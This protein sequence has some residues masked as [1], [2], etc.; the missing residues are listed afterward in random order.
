MEKNDEEKCNEKLK[1]NWFRNFSIKSYPYFENDEIVKVGFSK[2][3]EFI[4]LLTNIDTLLISEYD[5]EE[6][7]CSLLSQEEIYNF[8]IFGED[9]CGAF[10]LEKSKVL[11]FRGFDLIKT[12]SIPGTEEKPPFL[13]GITSYSPKI[14]SR[15]SFLWLVG[16]EGLKQVNFDPIT[17]QANSGE[18]LTIWKNPYNISNFIIL[19]VEESEKYIFGLAFDQNPKNYILQ[20]YDLASK[21]ST[22]FH[23]EI[24]PVLNNKIFFD[25]MNLKSEHESKF[26]GCGMHGDP[27]G[28]SIGQI[29]CFKIQ[30]NIEEEKIELTQEKTRIFNEYSKFIVMRHLQDSEFFLGGINDILLV[31]YTGED[32][33]IKHVFADVQIGSVYDIYFYNNILYS[34]SENFEEACRRIEFNV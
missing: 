19:C 34:V 26:I 21:K 6:L 30:N 4:Y 32:F 3:E 17:C 1:T 5:E 11:F 16:R 20:I 22:S 13:T 14:Y 33:L 9:G 2:K 25:L 8:F 27:Q 7:N 10:C 24:S 31:F 29:T 23:S 12:L 15:N 18:I 28:E